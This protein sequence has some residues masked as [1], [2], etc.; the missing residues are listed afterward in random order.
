MSKRRAKS[1]SL[2]TAFHVQS[3]DYTTQREISML[4]IVNSKGQTVY[5]WSLAPRQAA[6]GLST[7]Q[8][9]G[10]QRELAR[11]GVALEAILERYHLSKP[12]DMS[13]DVY[14][15]AMNSLKKTKA[16]SSSAA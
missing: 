5:T 11:T 9:T 6:P 12:E 3:I 1:S 2:T 7:A 15:Q 10:L 8:M 16:K 4:V 14:Q 13:P